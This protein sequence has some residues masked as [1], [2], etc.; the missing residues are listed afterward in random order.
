MQVLCG[1]QS[2]MQDHYTQ[3]TLPKLISCTCQG[4]FKHHKVG[5]IYLAPQGI[6]FPTNTLIM[7]LTSSFG[8]VNEIRVQQIEFSEAL[9][10]TASQ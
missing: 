8:P 6:L 4:Y 10:L 7:C 1:D 5:L 3:L 2:H 9:G